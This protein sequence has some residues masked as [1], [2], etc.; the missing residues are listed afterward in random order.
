MER[1]PSGHGDDEGSVLEIGAPTEN[2]ESDL[3]RKLWRQFAEATTPKEIG[4]AHV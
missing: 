3:D 2:P 1:T 4:R